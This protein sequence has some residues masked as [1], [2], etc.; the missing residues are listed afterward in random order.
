MN[1]TG[2]QFVCW[3]W[4]EDQ[5]SR[6]EGTEQVNLQKGKA[7]RRWLHPVWLPGCS[8]CW[9]GAGEPGFRIPSACGVPGGGDLPALR[10]RLSVGH[11]GH[12]SRGSG[13]PLGSALPPGYPDHWGWGCFPVCLDSAGT[14]LCRSRTGSPGANSSLGCVEI[15]GNQ[16]LSIFG[17]RK[18]NGDKSVV[19]GL[20]GRADYFGIEFIFFLKVRDF[21]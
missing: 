19:F 1:E 16:T 6:A 15:Q 12:S 14:Q 9:D 7:Q 17:D 21:A 8:L 18:R 4:A 5:L 10:R 13:C 2:E 20:K 3:R 11:C